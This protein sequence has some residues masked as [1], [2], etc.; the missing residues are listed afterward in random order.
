MSNGAKENISVPQIPFHFHNDPEVRITP[1]HVH[2]QLCTTAS[3]VDA[4]GGQLTDI[5]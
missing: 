4:D 3:L 5:R 2:R 1:G